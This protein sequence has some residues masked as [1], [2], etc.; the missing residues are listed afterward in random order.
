MA[1]HMIVGNSGSGKTTYLYKAL[2][3]SSAQCP[4]DRFFFI[5]PEQYT[6]QAQRDIVERSAQHGTIQI[7]IVSFM[8]LAYRI[9]EELGADVTTVLED[10][11]KGM[12][13]RR[14]LGELSE[15][16]KLYHN[17][18]D[19]PGFIDQ[20]K[21]VLSEFYQ[22]DVKL[23]DIKSM[24]DFVGEE[25]LLAYKLS[26]LYA[27]YSA[28][29]TSIKGSYQ[30]SEQLIDLLCEIAPE[31]DLLQ[32]AYFFID[33]F[34]GFTPIQYRLLG[35]LME[36][37]SEFYITVT[38]DEAAYYSKNKQ[39]HL[40]ALSKET[41]DELITLYGNHGDGVL[42][43]ILLF[44][45]LPVR[46]QDCPE[47]AALEQNLFRSRVKPYSKDIANVHLAEAKSVRCEV[48][49]VA[50]QIAQ[51]IREG[52]RYRD[53]AVV[54]ANEDA[55]NPICKQVFEKYQIPYFLD[56]SDEVINHPFVEALHAV[57]EM[58]GSGYMGYDYETVMRYLNTGLTDLKGYEIEELDNYLLATNTVGMNPWMKGFR[59]IPKSYWVKGTTEEERKLRQAQKERYLKRINALRLR[60]MKPLKPLQQVFDQEVNIRTKVTA[61]YQFMVDSRY[62]TRLQY[63]AEQLEAQKEYVLAKGW[64]NIYGKMIDL[65]DKMVDVLGDETDIPNL[66][67][68]GIL[69]AGLEELSLG[70]IPPTMDQVVVGDFTRTRLSDIS[71]LFVLG[72]NDSYIPASHTS[73]NLISDQDRL[74]LAEG[75]ITLAPNQT[76]AAYQEQFYLYSVFTKPK[77]ELYISYARMDAECK[78][79]RPAYLVDRV[80]QILPKLEMDFWDADQYMIGTSSA[81]PVLIDSLVS[82][83]DVWNHAWNQRSNQNLSR[84]VNQELD[85]NFAPNLD[86]E[87]KNQLLYLLRLCMDSDAYR[88][89]QFQSGFLYQNVVENLS[90]ALARQ[91][92]GN[93]LYMSVTRLEKYAGCAFAHFLQYGLHLK[94]RESYEFESMDFGNVMHKV[95][96]LFHRGIVEDGIDYQSL[97]PEMLA[98]R[99]EDCVNQA[100]KVEGVDFEEYTCRD[101]R[102]L[103]TV[104]RMA[105]R[106]MDVLCQHLKLGE[107]RPAEFELTFGDA[108]AQVE[109]PV[110]E[111]KDS[112]RL[113]LRGVIDRLDICEEKQ[114]TYLK[115]IDYKTGNTV[116]DITKFYY[117]LQ[118]QLMTYLLV[119]QKNYATHGENKAAAALYFHISDPIIDHIHTLYGLEEAHQE[120][121]KNRVAQDLMK[122]YVMNGVISNR[123]EILDKF[124][125]SELGYKYQTIP[126]SYNKDGSLAKSSK[127]IDDQVLQNMLVYTE[128]KVKELAQ[129]MLDG[130]VGIR[131]YIYKQENGCK[132]CPM[133]GVCLIDGKHMPRARVLECKTVD[134]FAGGEKDGE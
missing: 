33:G 3:E 21:S 64:A 50:N 73:P 110:Y 77:K 80:K 67:L 28:F 30:V 93:Q 100:L 117:G 44:S 39:H 4:E 59:R 23:E 92:Y 19:K 1:L 47:I 42:D 91:L 113:T 84:S 16:L 115:V 25:S 88:F 26:D 61:I 112:G 119:A 53:I 134:V 63:H 122:K 51:K 127:C 22:Y 116:F 69:N 10:H 97:T 27:I 57:L 130:E 43:S 120:T 94:D 111:L 128:E 85:Q 54:S 31:S 126:V 75:P 71:C 98:Q 41:Y 123:A 129:E 125:P 78:G 81:I 35:V 133:S 96:E 2:L 7:D 60:V 37:G 15:D 102:F 108:S 90:P 74:M 29:E 132:Y 24:I 79:L 11:G 32:E 82:Y 101:R 89:S 114:K 106:T 14:I 66:E 55:Y 107:F 56:H 40:F 95:S 99:T 36:L 83:A 118:L 65:L 87:Q 45:D 13:L 58:V 68:V 103:D 6:L 17:M 20:V 121:V 18:E 62:E 105:H 52:A 124:E 86:Q 48:E 12:L 34:T 8:R 46:F 109:G 38:M 104:S 72:L 76:V 70:M 131:P 49:A 5:V 9:F